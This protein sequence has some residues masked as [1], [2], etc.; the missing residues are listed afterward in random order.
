MENKLK[1]IKI[2]YT[3]IDNTFDSISDIEIQPDKLEKLYELAWTYCPAYKQLGVNYHWF[4]KQAEYAT[5]IVLK[6]QAGCR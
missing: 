6:K 1:K 4:I 3:M 2:D 5:N